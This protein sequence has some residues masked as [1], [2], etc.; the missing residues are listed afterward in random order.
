MPFFSFTV[1][2]VVPIAAT[3]VRLFAPFPNRWKLWMFDLSWM[4]IVYVPGL[5]VVL[6]IV[7]VHAGP[8]VPMRMLLRTLAPA[9]PGHAK[10]ATTAIR[11]APTTKR[12]MA[13]PFITWRVR[14]R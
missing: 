3:L 11:A 14:T 8:S 2:L 1:H 6:F 7:I 13:A 12:F 10:A 5:T 9:T 4:T